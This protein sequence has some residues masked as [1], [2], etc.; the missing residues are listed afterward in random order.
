MIL[1]A[2]Q[3]VPPRRD[4]VLEALYEHGLHGAKMVYSD[5]AATLLSDFLVPANKFGKY[6]T[7][8]GNCCR[9]LLHSFAKIAI[10]QK[11]GSL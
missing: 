4:Y 7:I 5:T 3:D 10:G 11:G 8:G 1:D 9:S 2:V 6:G